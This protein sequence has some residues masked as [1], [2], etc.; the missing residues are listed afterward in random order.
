MSELEPRPQDQQPPAPPAPSGSDPW[1][2]WFSRA[3][4]VVGLAIMVFEARP[5]GEQRPWLLLFAT[6]MMLGGVGL[7]MVLRWVAGRMAP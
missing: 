1:Q 5:G 2:I 4:Q 6:G 7:Q 3:V